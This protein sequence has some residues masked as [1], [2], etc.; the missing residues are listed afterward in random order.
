MEERT[1]QQEEPVTKKSIFFANI[2]DLNATR[3]ISVMINECNGL[4]NQEYNKIDMSEEIEMHVKEA[5]H[6]LT[7]AYKL[8]AEMME[9]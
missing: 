6:H 9:K 3:S 1:K 8:I 5:L 2:N 4:L 7:E